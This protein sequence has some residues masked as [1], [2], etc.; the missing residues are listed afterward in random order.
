MILEG[1]K[2]PIR[3]HLGFYT[4]PISFIGLPVLSVPIY[5]PGEL[6]VGVQLI[7][8]P[9][10]EETIFKVAAVLEQLGVTQIPPSRL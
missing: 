3:P 1:K 5:I 9:F 2:V 7:A 10:D 4:Q 8:K 6:P